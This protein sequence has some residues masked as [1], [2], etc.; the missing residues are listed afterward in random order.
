MSTE[1]QN[2]TSS[3]HD[4]KLPVIRRVPLRDILDYEVRA[5]WWASWVSA[6]WMQNLAGTYY[7]WKVTRKYKRY[8]WSKDVQEHGV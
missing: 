1:V 7:A 6:D 4:A 2:T 3:K 8:K 5:S